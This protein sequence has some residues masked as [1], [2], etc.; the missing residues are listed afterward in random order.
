MVPSSSPSTA[1]RAPAS[2]LGLPK[3]WSTGTQ[4]GPGRPLASSA[5]SSFAGGS[6]PM[7]A[8]QSTA[9]PAV[10]MKPSSA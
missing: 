1:P 6:A 8:N 7:R 4:I 3:P 2:Q 9:A 10:G 5:S